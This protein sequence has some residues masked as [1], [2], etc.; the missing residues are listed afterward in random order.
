MPGFVPLDFDDDETETDGIDE[1]GKS[2]PQ[3]G[4]L[5]CSPVS[6]NAPGQLGPT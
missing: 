1:P 4:P 2:N 5:T 3:D 6:Y